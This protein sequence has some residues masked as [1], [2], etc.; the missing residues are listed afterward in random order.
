V[1]TLLAVLSS[2][3]AI[4]VVPGTNRILATSTFGQIGSAST[5]KLKTAKSKVK[6]NSTVNVTGTL[7][8][9]QGGEQVTVLAR[10]T[11]AKGGTKWSKQTVTVS[12]GGTFTTTWKVAKG[13]IFVARWAGD[14]T[15]DGDGADPVIVKLKKK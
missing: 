12:L 3:G 15:H 4:L 7:A 5:L 2:R 6:K 13:T 1:S 11:N 14:A 8:P 9:S 10:Q